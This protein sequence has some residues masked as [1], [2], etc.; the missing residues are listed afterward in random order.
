M[1]DHAGVVRVNRFY[2]AAGKEKAVADGLKTIRDRANA[3]EGCFGAQVSRS[4]ED[5]AVLVVVSRWVDQAALERFRA[6][7][8]IVAEQERIRAMLTGPHRPEHLVPI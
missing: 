1:A 8:G 6:E 4:Q 2:P 5:P 7:P 3:A